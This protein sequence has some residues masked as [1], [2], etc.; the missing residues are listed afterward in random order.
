[1][2]GR[3]TLIAP[4]K[5]LEELFRL[6]ILGELPPRYNIAPVRSG[7]SVQPFGVPSNKMTAPCGSETILIDPDPRGTNN[8]PLPHPAAAS[9]KSKKTATAL[10]RRRKRSQMLF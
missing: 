8:C 1:M 5:M 7:C 9:A 4:A 10:P 3:Y 2:C 6:D